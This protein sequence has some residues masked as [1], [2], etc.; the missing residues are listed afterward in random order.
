MVEKAVEVRQVSKRYGNKIVLNNVSFVVRKGTIH[1]F[2]GPNGAGKTTTLRILMRLVVKDVSG[3]IY[4]EGKSVKNDP[5]CAQLALENWNSQKER[6]VLSKLRKF[7]FSLPSQQFSEEQSCNSL[8]TG[9]KKALQVFILSICRP[10]KEKILVLDEVFNGLDPSLRRDLFN[11][12][13]G[14]RDKGGT[15]L[16]STHILSDL[17][18]LADDITMIKKGE[19]VYTGQKTADVEQT[20]EDYFFEK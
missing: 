15:I 13:K 17:D 11:N 18:K 5:H 20:Y 2:I 1:G 12:L 10:V 14:I 9:Q 3:D 6:E 7:L 19:I 16:L 8:S 4:I